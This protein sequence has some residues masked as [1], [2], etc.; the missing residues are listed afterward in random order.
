M[1]HPCT[2][3][4]RQFLITTAAAT[5]STMQRSAFGNPPFDA[6]VRERLEQSFLNPSR[7]AKP[8]IWWLWGESTTTHDGITKDLEAYQRVGFG[9]VVIYEQVFTDRPEALKSLSP[10]WMERVRFA[11]AECE[12]LGLTLEF[13]VSS[14]YVAGGPWITPELGMQRLVASELNVEGG[15]ALSAQLPLPPT[16]LDFYRDVAI[17]AY[18]SPSGIESISTAPSVTSSVAGLDLATL[19]DPDARAKVRISPPSQGGAVFIEMDFARPFTARSLSY[20]QR[21]NSKATVIATQVPGNW[22]DDYY[23]MNMR[24]NP[25]LGHLEA[26]SDG[27]HWETCCELPAIGYQQD[28][29]DRLTVSFPKVTASRFRWNLQ[30]W[31]HNYPNN[32]NDLLLGNVEL[33][34]EARIDRWESKSGNVVDFSNRDRTPNYTGE[35]VIDP[36]KIIDLTPRLNQ[37]GRLNWDVP[38]GRWTILRLGHTPTGARTKH[39]RPETM[40]LECDKLSA[41]ATRVQFEKYLGRILTELRGVPGAVVAGAN[42]DSAEHGSQNWTLDFPD[43]FKERRGYDLIRYLPAMAGRVVGSNLVSDRFLFDVRRTIADMM[44]DEYYGTMQ[45]VCHAEGMT[46]MAQ[47]PGIATC[48]PSD[49]I[50]AKGRTDI[51][52]GEFWASQPNGTMDCKE[53]ASAA[54]VYG[55]PVAAAESFTGSQCDMHPAKMKPLAD[56][57]LANGI[58]RFVVLG[59]NHQ[60]W[61]DRRPGVDEDRFFLPFQRHNTWW[62]FSGAFW[63]TLARSSQMMREGLPAIDILYHLGND[64]PLKIVTSRMRPVPPDGYDYDVCG[65]EILL[66]TSVQD[67]RLSLPGGMSYHLLILAGGDRMTLPA[68]RKLRELLADGATVLAPAKPVGSPSLADGAASDEEIRRIADELWGSEPI[69]PRGMRKI[70]RGR[71]AWG[72]P[73]AELLIKLGIPKDFEAVP[74]GRERTDLLFAHRRTLTEDIYFVSNHR[75]ESVT[76]TG[77]FRV[78]DRVPQAWNPETGQISALPGFRANQGRIEV[79]LRLEQT[80]SI[81]VVFGD[82]PAQVRPLPE[83]VAEAPIFL[84]LSDAWSVTFQKE[85]GGA[86]DV[87]LPRLQS[88]TE[89]S[90]P[91]IRQYSGTATYRKLINISKLP[92]GRVLLDLGQVEVVAS[93]SLNGGEI[94]TVWKTPYALDVTDSLRSGENAIE[95]KVANLW[96]NRLIADAALPENER[97]SWVSSNPYSSTDPS[98]PSGLI[99]PVVLRTDKIL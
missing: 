26:S 97:I 22:S 51:P 88:W 19:Y 60:P 36:A 66:R 29:W 13:N 91:G 57:A 35:E 1:S 18:P 95:V 56:A 38:P 52:M 94:G 59:G 67:G 84:E 72:M 74:P 79:P 31:G 98:V 76:F 47:A 48:L 65:D 93:V 44:S 20:S 30:G 12:R 49:N 85:L 50:Q 92:A 81:F 21:P 23:G 46:L 27:V 42:M 40:G 45:K 63:S 41:L 73:P 83:L 70:G 28:N 6:T 82:H 8:A 53:A 17:L 55:L 5:A 87:M 11:A 37:D 43:Q 86:G 90:H 71:L 62:Q 89:D 7:A 96:T 24:L 61:D 80:S 2:W 39:G 77:V 99:G 78:Q 58:N 16:K 25:P 64:T 34:G 10:E 4:R 68:L 14:G 3:S 33:R 75:S 69:A 15:R 9:G 54:H 32:D